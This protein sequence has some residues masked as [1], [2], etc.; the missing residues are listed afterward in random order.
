MSWRRR[1]IMKRTPSQPPMSASMKMREYSRSK[2]RNTSAGNVKM[3]P[4]AIDWPSLP[5]V[6]TILFSRIEARPN[7]RRMLIDSTAADIVYTP[8]FSGVAGNYLRGS[9]AQTGLD[10]DA[11]PHADKSQMNFG[12]GGTAERK[13]W[14]DIWSAGQSV[15]GIDSAPALATL[16]DTME[17]EYREALARVASP[18]PDYSIAQESSA[19]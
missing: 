5:V 10:P 11:L 12:A 18:A 8:L 1:G 16:V 17:R 4:D 6:W 19:P 9:V 15:S 7:A 3:T 14:K 13:A 2:P